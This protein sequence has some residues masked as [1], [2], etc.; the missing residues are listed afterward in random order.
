MVVGVWMMRQLWSFVPGTMHN[1]LA[2]RLRR[3]STLSLALAALFFDSEITI[4][5]RFL[6][7]FSLF[8]NK[9]LFALGN[10]F[11]NFFLGFLS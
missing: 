11:D 9:T 1:H 6:I 4:S 7:Q 2:D 10:A 5:V 8:T 3:C